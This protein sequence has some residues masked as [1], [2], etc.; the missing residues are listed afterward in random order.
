MTLFLRNCFMKRFRCLE[1]FWR[2]L[3]SGGGG[4][5]QDQLSPILTIPSWAAPRQC[6]LKE[7]SLAPTG[8]LESF[9]VLLKI[10]AFALAVIF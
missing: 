1:R 3:F 2:S 10:T 4:F 6:F 5:F 8:I 9:L 7:Y